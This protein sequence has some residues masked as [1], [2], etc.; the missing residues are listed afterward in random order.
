MRFVAGT[1]QILVIGAVFAALV[2]AANVVSLD[3]VRDHPSAGQSGDDGSVATALA[4]YESVADQASEVPTGEVDPIVREIPLTAPAAGQR[5]ALA[6]SGG[7][8]ARSAV[9]LA[10]SEK[11]RATTVA[12]TKTGTTT[13]VSDPQDVTGFGTVGVTWERGQNLSEDDIALQIRTNTGGTWGAWSDLDYHDD[14]GP[15]TGSAEARTARPGTDEALVGHVDQVQVKAEI[16]QGQ[17]PQDMTLAVI[18]PGKA[19]SSAK[20][21]PQINTN[22]LP[23]VPD[24]APDASG[25]LVDS[26]GTANGAAA[27]TDTSTGSA[28]GLSLAAADT[29]PTDSAAV[30]DALEGA[31]TDDALDLAATSVAKP[32]IYSRAQWGAD[33]KIREQTAP[34]YGTIH[35]AFVH[36]TVNANDYTAAEVPGIIRS[37]YAYHVKSK[38]WRDIGYNFLV[39]RFGRIWEGRYGGVSRPVVGAHTENYNN[40][41]FAMSAIGNYD[42]AQPSQEIIGAYAALFAWKLSLHGISASATSAKISGRTFSSPIMGH[43]DTK[44]T[45]CP[46]KYLYARIPDIRRATAALQKGWAFAARNAN[47]VGSSYPDIIARRSSDKRGV[48][49]PTNGVSGFSGTVSTFG[50]KKS[51]FVLSPDLNGDGKAD[52]VAWNG[53]GDLALRPGNGAGAFG[54]A[55]YKTKAARGRNLIIPLGDVNGD[56][57]NDLA[58]RDAKTGRLVLLLGTGKGGFRQG[59]I[60]KRSFKAFNWIGAGDINGD[61]RVDL[62]VRD[63]KGNLSWLPGNGHGTFGKKRSLGGGWQG[64]TSLAVADFNFDGR[65]DVIYRSASTK[66]GYVRLGNGGTGFSGNL[67]PYAGF[68]TEGPISGATQVVGGGS[69]DILTVT[70]GNLHLLKKTTA[71][72]LGTPVVTNL[73]LA[74]ANLVLN[75]GD[76]NRDGKGDV[77]YRT[78]D[79]KLYLTL[80]NGAGTFSGAYLLGNFAGYTMISAVGDMTGDGNADLMAQ[81]ASGMRL[82]PGNG[83]TG[84]STSYAV[85]NRIAGSAQVPGG[86]WDADKAPDVLVRNGSSL[87]LYKGNGPGGLSSPKVVSTGMG[88]Y[89]WVIGV[90][91]LA[92]SGH[93]D[94]VVRDGAGTLYSLRGKSDGTLSP[95]RVMGYG[96]KGYDLAG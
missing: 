22:D 24:A 14:H 42:I 76:W 96:F 50:G 54:K 93:S 55:A 47:L 19:T 17:V 48:I 35:G 83:K 36:H 87:L 89:D 31:T 56:R 23:T 77:L 72:D 4:A 52:V 41:S 27:H 85:Y 49:I 88:A 59:R 64:A 13:I 18:D 74:K 8:A 30:A 46:G 51:S 11:L 94:L 43:R 92:G 20:Q 69:P 84:V 95:R 32:Y 75:A 70:N 38:G 25:N 81:N 73:N 44:S 80:G 61:K 7:D 26:T 91:P 58:A 5:P 6:T 3:V 1:Q 28:D 33:E 29:D 86:A 9:Y 79:G 62:V 67:G 2:P 12:D 63:T 57:K 68:K 37:I 90:G 10:G 21:S 15:D 78:T 65:A 34:S 45:A 66:K 16:T 53:A 82:F 40:D 60:D 71:T 39:D